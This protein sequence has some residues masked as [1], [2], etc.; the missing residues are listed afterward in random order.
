MATTTHILALLCCVLAFAKGQEP[1]APS[2]GANCVA[3]CAGVSSGDYQSCVGCHVYVTCS[4]GRKFDNRPC[5]ASLVWDD[6]VKQCRWTSDTCGVVQGRFFHMDMQANDL[7]EQYIDNDTWSIYEFPPW[8]T[9]AVATGSCD[10]RVIYKL[11]PPA[12]VQTV[13]VNIK[14][15]D[16]AI[17]A[18][19]FLLID[20]GSLNQPFKDNTVVYSSSSRRL[21][22]VEHHPD[23]I[24]RFTD[25]TAPLCIRVS[26]DSVAFTGGVVS[27]TV[28]DDVFSSMSTKPF[29]IALNID[30]FNMAG[31]TDIVDSLDGATGADTNS[32]RIS[33]GRRRPGGTRRGRKKGCTKNR[34][35]RP[36]AKEEATERQN[37]EP[38]GSAKLIPPSR[39]KVKQLSDTSVMLR[40][41]VPNND[42]LSVTFFK[43][44]YKEMTADKRR[45]RWHTIDEDILSSA[46]MYEVSG[47]RPGP[48]DNQPLGGTAQPSSETSLDEY[49]NT[50]NTKKSNELLYVV[51]GTVL[52]GMMLLLIVLMAM[53]AWRQQQQSRMMAAMEGRNKFDDPARVIHTDSMRKPMAAGSNGFLLNGLN[54]RTGNGR[55]GNGYMPNHGQTNGNQPH[56]NISVNPMTE[57]ED[58]KYTNDRSSPHVDQV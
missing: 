51:L 10:T 29:L 38:Q 30:I 18:Y 32:S 21:V 37:E 44:Q 36:E 55:T 25:V 8:N 1:P 20:I 35:T 34:R 22:N 33:P 27:K 9:N 45:R 7:G 50:T 53:C 47:L 46:R 42:G 56:M 2:T 11:N 43:V 58:D 4:H 57:L 39:P 17:D 26:N 49:P 19:S 31:T 6:N 41:N 28:S 48:F 23:L 54:G 13:N 40:W 12:C 15:E 16:N 14:T 3:D 24:Q 5:P 52:G